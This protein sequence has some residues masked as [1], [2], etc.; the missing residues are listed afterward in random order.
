MD[1]TSFRGLDPPNSVLPNE[2]D[3]S[4]RAIRQ[5]CVVPF[6]NDATVEGLAKRAKDRR[7]AYDSY[8]RFIHMYSDV[9]LGIEHHQ[10]E[11]ILGEYKDEKALGL[12]TALVE[13]FAETL[14]SAQICS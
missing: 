4:V 11:D 8:R 3:L 6:L 7:F 13:S 12:D 9:V 1:S 5:E 2:S 14:P 10:F